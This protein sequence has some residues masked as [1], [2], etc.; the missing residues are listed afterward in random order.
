MLGAA[1][2]QIFS[3]WPPLWPFI[4]FPVGIHTVIELRGSACH[5]SKY[6]V[7][8]RRAFNEELDGGRD[9]EAELTI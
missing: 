9:Q 6:S 1:R 8:Y 7:A 3:L 4:L 2:V 5:A